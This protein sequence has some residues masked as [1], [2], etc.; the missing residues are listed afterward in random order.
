MGKHAIKPSCP[1][2][3]ESERVK[4]LSGG[5]QGFYRYECGSPCNTVW[6]QR[7]LHAAQDGVDVRMSGI[8]KSRKQ[9]ACRRCGLPKRGHTCLAIGDVNAGEMLPSL[10]LANA[11]AS[12]SLLPPLRPVAPDEAN[13]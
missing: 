3:G 1:V 11:L 13:P 9:Y 6:Q 10:P 12:M 5:T 7:P 4:L 8:G 2:C